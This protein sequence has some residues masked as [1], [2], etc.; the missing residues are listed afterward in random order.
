MSHRTLYLTLGAFMA[1]L[2]GCGERERCPPGTAWLTPES[3]ECEPL[4]DGGDGG[5]DG[6]RDAEP[7]DAQS[8]DAGPC[9][10]KCTGETPLCRESDGRCVACLT[11]EDCMVS[12]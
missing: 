6:G 1:L 11:D 10:G 3:T 9:G 4:A 2:V 7:S 5:L 8:P 12:G